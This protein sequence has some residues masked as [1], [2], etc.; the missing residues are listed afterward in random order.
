VY[1]INFKHMIWVLLKICMKI[2]YAIYIIQ[3]SLHAIIDSV[4]RPVYS[5]IKINLRV[6]LSKDLADIYETR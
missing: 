6:Y 3:V 4:Q 5:V 2:T 1:L